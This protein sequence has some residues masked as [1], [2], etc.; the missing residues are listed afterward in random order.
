MSL[1]TAC[2]IKKITTF[3]RQDFFLMVKN[4]VNDL[5]SYTYLNTLHDYSSYLC[6]KILHT[7][8]IHIQLAHMRTQQKEKK[9]IEVEKEERGITE[10]V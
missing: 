3:V 6:N 5:I 2:T 10:V 1:P 4:V 8:H 7:Q 9:C